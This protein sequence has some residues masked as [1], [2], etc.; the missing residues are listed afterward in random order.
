MSIRRGAG[1]SNPDPRP[2]DAPVP[3]ATGLAVTFL[4]A[5][6]DL[7]GHGFLYGGSRHLYG[8]KP[9]ART[10]PGKEWDR[11]TPR[12]R[13]CGK[14]LEGRLSKFCCGV[15][16]R[17]PRGPWAARADGPG[18]AQ[19]PAPNPADGRAEHAGVGDARRKRSA[20]SS[21]ASREALD[22]LRRGPG[23]RRRDRRAPVEA[24]PPS[25][26]DLTPR[27]GATRCG[28]WGRGPVDLPLALAQTSP[29][30]RETSGPARPRPGPPPKMPKL[31][32]LG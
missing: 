6:G 5:P 15:A 12:G 19:R 11:T 20:Q 18:W 9:V 16:R 4:S 3:R 23:R 27:A 24:R 7:C 14:G 30:P 2:L 22:V 31:R 21:P 26:T 32:K 28:A 25:P 29:T 1:R 17:R 10:A 13:G 8:G